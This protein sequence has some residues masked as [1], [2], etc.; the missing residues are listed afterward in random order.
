MQGLPAIRFVKKDDFGSAELRANQIAAA[1]AARGRDARAV[2]GVGRDFRR[3]IV[4]FVKHLEFEEAA[5]AAEQGNLV[6]YDVVDKFTFHDFS[7]YDPDEVRRYF[8][9]VDAAIHPNEYSRRR[10]SEYFPERCLNTVIHHH[11]DPR[12]AEAARKQGKRAPDRFRLGYIGAPENFREVPEAVVPI[13]DFQRQL[14]LCSLFTCHYSARPKD[15]TGA[16]LKPG[17]KLSV[18]ASVG[19]NVVTTRDESAM[20]LLGPDYPY[21]AP[22]DEKGIA[23]TI[24]MARESFGGK[25]WLGAL[26][27]MKELKENTS[28]DSVVQHGYLRLFKE[29]AN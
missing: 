15:S 7:A 2:R 20:D 3:G 16:L 14:E 6:V 8:S 22:W 24:A 23:E 1:L 13:F 18:A 10:F 25:T 19:A 17:T 9:A 5:R 21:L 28:L 27:M 29:L 26:E 4:V 12:F 11:W